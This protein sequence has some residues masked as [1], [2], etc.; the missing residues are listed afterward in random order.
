[1]TN[2]EHQPSSRVV[3]GDMT[4]CLIMPLSIPKST[5][6]SVR[7]LL[8]FRRSD[9]VKDCNT[10]EHNI[11]WVQYLLRLVYSVSFDATYYMNLAPYMFSISNLPFIC[12]ITLTSEHFL[13]SMRFEIILF[14][15][16]LHLRIT[17]I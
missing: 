9:C 3:P 17:L 16:I 6:I 8:V 11:S 14:E 10:M 13:S 1:M 2:K 7:L 15:L 5:K 4:A 12:V